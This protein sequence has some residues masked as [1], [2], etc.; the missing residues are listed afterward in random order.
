MLVNNA[1]TLYCGEFLRQELEHTLVQHGRLTTLDAAALFFTEDYMTASIEVVIVRTLALWCDFETRAHAQRLAGL[2]KAVGISMHLRKKDLIL[3]RLAA[4][5][6][7]IGKVAIPDKILQ[8][9]GPLDDGERALMRL[10][11]ELGQ[12]ILHHAG[13]LFEQIA[14]L[15]V[16]HHEAWDGSG[17]PAGLIGKKIPLLA[18]I[19]AVVD[20][21]DAMTSD[22]VYGKPLPVLQAYQE[23]WRCAG[24]QYDPLVVDAFLHGFVFHSSKHGSAERWHPTARPMWKSIYDQA[25]WVR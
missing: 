14:L 13:G 9:N 4:L 22:R 20:S 24:H 16:A 5:L 25:V 15:V 19:L 8:K 12:T 7:D 3:L 1:T 17:Y 18:R 11:P 2:A 21:Y 23:L 6:H 10:H